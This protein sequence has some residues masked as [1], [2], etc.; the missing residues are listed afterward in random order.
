MQEHHQVQGI[1]VT[2]LNVEVFHIEPREQESKVIYPLKLERH[3]FSYLCTAQN[4]ETNEIGLVTESN[5][6]IKQKIFQ[7]STM[8]RT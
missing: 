7:S 1:D 8:E 6:V 3:N 4:K 2:H 5:K